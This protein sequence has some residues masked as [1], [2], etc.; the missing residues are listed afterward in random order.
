MGIMTRDGTVITDE[1]RTITSDMT[2]TTTGVMFIMTTVGITISRR[3]GRISKTSNVT[4]AVGEI[5]FLIAPPSLFIF[6]QPD[7]LR[8]SQVTI[9]RPFDELDLCDR[10]RYTARSLSALGAYSDSFLQFNEVA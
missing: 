7:K 1:D 9:R 2:I 8:M 5:L 4:A 6:S 3:F 10:L